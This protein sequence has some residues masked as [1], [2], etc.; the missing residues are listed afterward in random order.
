MHALTPLERTAFLLRH[1]EDQS[2]SEIA[3]ALDMAPNAVK[4][5]IFRAVQKLRR[6]L[7][8]LRGKT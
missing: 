2:T 5:A 6:R 4:Q 7:A 1:V 3:A 8:P